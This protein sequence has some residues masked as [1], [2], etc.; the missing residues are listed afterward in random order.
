MSDKF[1]IFSIRAS[2]VYLNEELDGILPKGWVEIQ[3][4]GIALFKE[5]ASNRETLVESRTDWSEKVASEIAQ[6]LELPVA[7]YELAVV[8][9]GDSKVPGILSFDLS[10]PDDEERFPIEEFL[11]QSLSQYNYPSDYNIGNVINALSENNVSCPPN[12]KTPEGIDNAADL[13]VGIVLLDAVISNSDRHDRNL[14]IV[15][16]TNGESYFSPV[17]DNGLSL[18]A[19]E[20]DEL[21][22]WIDPQ[23]YNKHYNFSVFTNENK[24]ISNLDAFKLAAELRPKAASIWLEQLQ[25]IERSQ[26]KSIFNRIPD[27]IITPLANDFALDLLAHNQKHLLELYPSI[28]YKAE[29]QKRVE[30]VAPILI[31]YLNLKKQDKVETPTASI[32]VD[33][34][35]KTLSYQDK[36]GSNFLKAQKVNGKWQDKG[37]NITR[38]K[39]EHFQK[40][41]APAIEQKREDIQGNKRQKTL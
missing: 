39:L 19:I 7:H 17:F 27:K 36:I 35:S 15:R 1:E 29:Q 40:K 14:D 2:D 18:G 25:K 16:Q 33:R 32:E 22:S 41:V 28:A 21:R 6:L 12:V 9:D 34:N 24:N 23:H 13:F 37:S 30:K 20:D 3:G 38:E 26:I 31:D 4:S 11:Q 10:Q 8:E 5:A